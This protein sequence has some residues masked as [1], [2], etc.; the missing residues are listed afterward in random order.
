M[1]LP[2]AHGGRR[3]RRRRSDALNLLASWITTT[4]DAA[5]ETEELWTDSP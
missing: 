4:F 5:L 1:I 3:A 2:D